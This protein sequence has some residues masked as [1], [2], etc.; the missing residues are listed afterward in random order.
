MGMVVVVFV[1]MV[2]VVFM[3]MVIGELFTCGLSRG[4]A[5]QSEKSSLQLCSRKNIIYFIV[6]IYLWWS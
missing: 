1:G 3:G 4:A 5:V 2:I 6:V